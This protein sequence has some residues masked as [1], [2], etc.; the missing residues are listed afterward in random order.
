MGHWEFEHSADSKAEPAAIWER[1]KD[2]DNWS[3]WS[4]KG[5]E[6]STL[7]GEFREGTG[8]TSKAPHLPMRSPRI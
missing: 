4:T 5:V 1:Y 6:Q 2:V 8:G 7:D 3:E